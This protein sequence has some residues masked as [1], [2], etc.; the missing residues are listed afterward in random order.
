[1]NNAIS[2]CDYMQKLTDIPS[3]LSHSVY[4]SLKEVEA[5]AKRL[6]QVILGAS[7]L[8]QTAVPVLLDTNNQSILEWKQNLR[9]TLE[10]QANFFCQ[11]LAN[12]HEGLHV[13]EPGGAMY[14][15]IRI[16]PSRFDESIQ[17]DLDFSK[18]LLKEENVFMLPG[19][20]FGV[21]NVCRVVFCAPSSIL[22]EAADRIEQ[23]CQRHAL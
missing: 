13:M 7:H 1:M 9:Y 11:A 6:A 20:C 5:G 3:I 16:D 4:G 2:F 10:E 15:M 14:A 23:F 22:R 8:A 19:T 18:L 12:V 21:S 17:N